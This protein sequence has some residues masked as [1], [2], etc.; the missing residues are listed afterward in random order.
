MILM[1][2]CLALVCF[3]TAR[4]VA[5]YY[6]SCEDGVA[7]ATLMSWCC[8]SPTSPS[9]AA[10]FGF[11]LEADVLKFAAYGLSFGMTSIFFILPVTLHIHNSHHK[12]K[13]RA[14]NGG[15]P[16]RDLVEPSRTRLPAGL[17]H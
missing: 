2:A 12:A 9:L 11:F 6:L 16:E 17:N 1:F 3:I 8:V 14:E 15:V 5:R 7:K 13:S 10:S 4:L